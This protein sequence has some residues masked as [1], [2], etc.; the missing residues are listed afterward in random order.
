MAFPLDLTFA[1]PRLE[2]IE[3]MV[4]DFHRLLYQ[5]YY[6]NPALQEPAEIIHESPPGL[7]L[8]LCEPGT[9]GSDGRTFVPTSFDSRSGRARRMRAKRMRQG[10]WTAL[11]GAGLDGMK[12]LISEGG[13]ADPLLPATTGD[14]WSKNH[15][16]IEPAPEELSFVAKVPKPID[17]LE[18][19]EHK[20]AD[21]M[22]KLRE[23]QEQLEQMKSDF[24]QT[25]LS[26]SSMSEMAECL[27][28][29][30]AAL[31]DALHCYGSG[32][33]DSLLARAALLSTEVEALVNSIP[34]EADIPSLPS[35]VERV[36]NK[37]ESLMDV[38]DRLLRDIKTE[39]QEKSMNKQI[40]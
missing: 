33:N 40:Y 20:L 1:G 28:Q 12:L 23:D 25:V 8:G 29:D 26:T 34:L 4:A 39:L 35:L 3:I 36:R 27:L 38:R 17:T 5:P 7:A 18:E 9:L 15:N 11:Y 2:R 10:L 21:T 24:A 30:A 16:V 31:S 32:E 14:A 22:E 37:C 13:R 19:V 6:I